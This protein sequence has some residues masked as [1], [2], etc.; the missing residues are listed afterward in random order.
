MA[1][2]CIVGGPSWD[3]CVRHGD[4]DGIIINKEGRA[5]IHARGMGLDQCSGEP[6][7]VTSK[8]GRPDSGEIL[9]GFFLVF[10]ARG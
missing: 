5:G 6:A 1:Q 2:G 9:C 8:A 3:T 10:G 7:L 4:S